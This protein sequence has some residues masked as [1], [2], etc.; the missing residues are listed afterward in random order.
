VVGAGI[1]FALLMGLVGGYLPARRA[2]RLPV[3]EAVR[4]V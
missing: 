1:L 4:A 2:A 3:A